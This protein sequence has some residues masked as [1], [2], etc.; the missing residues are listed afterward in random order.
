MKP[1]LSLTL[2][3]LLLCSTAL[4]TQ[5]A[6]MTEFQRFTSYPF[7]ERSYREAKKDNWAE[8]ERLTRHVLTRVPNNDEAR[9]LLV[10]ALAHQRRYKEAEAMAEQLGD[11]PEY[12][13]ALLELR[14]T[15]IEQDPPAA[16]QVEDWLAGADGM[17]RVRL[18]Q[19]YSLSLAKFGGAG[20]ALD[21][22]SQ[23][24]PRDDGQVLR[25]ARA[26]FA[27]QLRNW[28]ETIEQLQPLA[29]KGQLPPEDW[30]R[31]ANAYVQQVDEKGLTKLLQSAPSTEAANQTRLAM[32]HRAI[33]VGHNQ[34]AQ[35][36]LQQLPTEQLQQPEQRQQL[37]ELAREGDDA[38]LVRQLSNE[39]QRPCLETVDWLSR[40]DP[41]VAREQFKGCPA[42]ADPRAYA[43]LKQRLYGDPVQ[44]PQPRTAAEWEKRYRQ[45]GDL[46]ALEQTTFLLLQQGR[47]EHARTL[48]EQAYDRRQGRLTPSL[49]QR[50]ANLY[51]RN[52]GP[53]NS[54]RLLELI[55]RV[56]ANAR[57][58]LLGRLAE[59]GQ[60]DA[61][62]QS[63]PA[64]PSEAGQFRALGRCAM[65]D[66]PG[67]AVVYY[68]AAERLGG[69][70]NR[71]P[72]AY[73][74]E[75]AGDS[76][77]ALPIWRSLPA[78]AWNDNARLTAARGA[79]NAGDA[80]AARRYWDAATHHSADDWALGAAIAQR[81]GDLQAALGFQ[82]QA[83]AHNPRA[84]HY[85]AAAST[86]QSAGDSAQSTAWLAEAVRLAPDQPRYRADYG[87]RLAGSQDLAQRRQSIPYLERATHDFPEDYR[88]G[89]TLALRYDEAENSAAARRELRRVIDV[90]ENLVDADDEYG[91]LEARKYR[92]RRAHESLSRRDTITLAS[93]WS[94]AGT[95][96]NDKFLDN[97]QRSGT[98]RRA[99]SQNVQLAMWDHALGEEPSRNGSTL[100]VYGRVLFGGQ[101][102]TDYAQ[103]MGTG[104]GLRYK[105]LG[106]ANLNLYAELYHQRQIDDDHYSGLSLGELLSPAKVGGNWGD[107]RHHAESSN[108]L[109]LRATASFLDQGDWRNDWRVDEDDW[110]ERFLYLD[111]A[112]WTRAGDHAWLSRYQQGHAW[113][114][115][116]NSPQTLMPY[117]F[118]EFSSQD[119]SNDWRQDAR[120][121]VG[122]RWQWWFDDDRYNAY[123]GSLK[124]RAEYQQS[125]G[126]NLYKSANGVLVGAEMTF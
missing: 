26:N 89:E 92:Q 85:Y 117:G 116:G 94:P 106:Q 87:M 118:F 35:R 1:R 47:N 49:L 104:L 66:R 103:S 22:L 4:A 33:A 43:V 46:A 23:L 71:L 96:T 52:D 28:K 29:D 78:S 82:R 20:K 11:G 40:H 90:E 101:S 34:L 6:P 45:S 44:P 88:L 64:N 110:N 50:L 14:L 80:N 24:P 112:W 9:A 126:G 36:W 18:W 58:Q 120:A 91:S 55:P 3:G 67:E 31:L 111:A 105:P 65:P 125:L 68:Q 86:A 61:V 113:K 21:W 17:Q 69:G 93:T 76:E 98:S 30:Q 77:A 97:G 109:L 56:D 79:L 60:C 83:L 57:A 51:A 19:A 108:D 16:S 84:D 100:S 115:P 99:Q 74:L 13:N 37:W 72:L 75:A 124:V 81:Q 32:A 62:R 39:L 7:M 102:R 73:A 107:L 123:R 2:S 5:A 63:I 53:F 114:L 8:V 54:R 121:G 48:L 15:W 42:N 95:S 41:E 38:Q 70:G 12:A 25:L 122:V 59:N 27:E 10:E 119:P